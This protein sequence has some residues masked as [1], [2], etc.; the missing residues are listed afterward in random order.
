[1]TSRACVQVRD[2]N[3]QGNIFIVVTLLH[4]V[5][6]SGVA[7][8]T[9]DAFMW[10]VFTTKPWFDREE[11]QYLGEVPTPWPAFVFTTQRSNSSSK[12]STPEQ[13]GEEETEVSG[14]ESVTQRKRVG[15]ARGEAKEGLSAQ[16]EAWIRERLFP[17]LCEGARIFVQESLDDQAG[18][19]M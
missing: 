9:F 14:V 12:N 4:I 1:M 15:A 11:L 18:T 19:G 17:A 8:G 6:I 5:L 7:A 16:K 2:P 3:L 13:K 10:E